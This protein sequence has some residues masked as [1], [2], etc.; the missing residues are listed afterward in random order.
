MTRNAVQTIANFIVKLQSIQLRTPS[1]WKVP[2]L[3][4]DLSTAARARQN[5]HESECNGT[6]T[7]GQLQRAQ[8]ARDRAINAAAEFGLAVFFQTDPRGM[9]MYLLPPTV[10]EPRST[11]ITDGIAVPY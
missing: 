4:A 9:P 7:P 8:R 5:F 6:T 3:V 10:K 11:Y 1:P 2:A